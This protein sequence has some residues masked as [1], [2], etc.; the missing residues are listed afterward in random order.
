LL[1]VY[2]PPTTLSRCRLT[3]AL[4]VVDVAGG[5]NESV[6][7]LASMG[8]NG[9]DRYA[10]WVRTNL[11]SWTVGPDTDTVAVAESCAGALAVTE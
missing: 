7:D 4:G 2:V 10:P 8:I 3:T 11:K 9:S 1:V 6:A 5:G